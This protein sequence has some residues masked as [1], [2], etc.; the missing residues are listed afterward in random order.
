MRTATMKAPTFAFLVRHPA[1]FIALGFG[2]GLSPVGPGTFGTLV[3]LPLAWLLD[4]HAGTSGWLAAIAAIT[5]VGTWCAHIT[6]RDLGVADHGSIVI[7]EIAAF[8]LV[9]FFAGAP[10]WRQALAF[11]LFRFF[12]IVKPPP[13]REIDRAMKNAVGVMADDFAAA[14]YTLLVLAVGDRLLGS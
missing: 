1:H 11:V 4:A 5:L 9:L 7:D 14:G 3:A 6:A 2:T 8:L 13:I 12:D 10:P